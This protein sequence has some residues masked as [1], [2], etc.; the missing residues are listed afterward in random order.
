MNTRILGFAA[1]AMAALAIAWLAL[2]APDAGAPSG[3]STTAPAD[4]PAPAKTT[5]PAPDHRT[6]PAKPDQDPG[7][8][9]AADQR[10]A[11]PFERAR[12]DHQAPLSAEDMVRVAEQLPRQWFAALDEVGEELEWDDQTWDKAERVLEEAE[13][14]LRAIS[15]QVES[16]RLDPSAARMQ[17]QRL[18][19][20]A[21]TKAEEVGGVKA[22]GRLQD[23]LGLEPAP[24][25]VRDPAWWD[26]TR[27]EGWNQ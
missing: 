1:A 23:A 6:T 17:Q 8:P 3:P 19:R 26:G 16:G 21:V 2:P 24:E 25:V 9:S 10:A 20:T 5:A 13:R 14:E 18:E 4:V 15:A 7:P 12:Y 22:V 27:E 11:A